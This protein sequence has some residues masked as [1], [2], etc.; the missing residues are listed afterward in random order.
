MTFGFLVSGKLGLDILLHFYTKIQ[1]EFVLTDKQSLGVIDFCKDNNLPCYIGN[2]R[3]PAVEDF[4]KYKEC[5]II[6][7]VNYLFLVDERIIKFPNLIAFNVHGSL[8]PKYRGRSPHVWA[9]ING[10]T[11]TGIT[12][13]LIELGCDTGAIIEQTVIPIEPED[14]GAILLNKYTEEYVPLIERTIQ[15]IASGERNFTHQQE[16]I[17]TFFTKRTPEDGKINW[18]W[19]ADRI[20]NWVRAQAHPYPGA[21]SFANE[22]KITINKLRKSKLGFHQNM[23]NGTVLSTQPLII[24]CSNFALE[25]TDYQIINSDKLTTGSVLK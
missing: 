7:S 5:D 19:Q 12:S 6:A 21:F 17:A 20:I 22:E 23:D 14:T 25:I 4:L 16:D 1:I 9:I 8:L 13:H 2:P 24:K 11:E 10:E 3:K 15:R 18:D